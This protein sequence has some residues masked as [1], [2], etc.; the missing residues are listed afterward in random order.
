MKAIAVCL[1]LF[2][3][4]VVSVFVAHDASALIGSLWTDGAPTMNKNM[5]IV[6]GVYA[7]CP[8][9]RRD[10]FVAELGSNRNIC[11]YG[12]ERLKIGTFNDGSRDKAVVVFPYSNAAH[13]LEGICDLHCYYA[14]DTDQLVTLQPIGQFGT[15]LV[16]YRRASHRI[17]VDTSSGEGVNYVFDTAHPDYEMK[18]DVGKYILT[19][20]F[21]VSRNGNWVVAELRSQGIATINTQSLATKQVTTT[22]IAYGYGLDPSEQLAISNDG[23]SVALAGQN[24]G[25]QVFDVTPDCGQQLIDTLSVLVTTRQCPSTDLGIRQLF[26]NFA[27][28]EYPRFFG[29][30]HQ[31]E[32]TVSSWVGVSRRVSFVTQGTVIAPQLKLLTLGDSFSS[33]EGEVSDDY[34][35]FGT[36][37]QFDRCHVSVRSYSAH[38]ATLLGIHDDEV[39]NV[40]CSGARIGDIV[41]SSG[42]YWGQG[43]RLGSSG[44]GVSATEKDRL[45][46]LAVATYQPGR[47]LQSAFIE[48]YDPEIIT[49]GVGGNDA[50]LMGKLRT[51]AMPGTC[52]WVKSPGLE[53]T[54]GEIK[55]LYDTLSS[56][57]TEVSSIAPHSK[58]FVLGYPDIIDP[59]GVCDPLLSFLLDKTE[60][61]FVQNSIHYMNTV[62]RAA[63]HKAN[64]HYVDLEHSFDGNNLCR[65]TPT[66]MNSVRI[67]DDVAIAGVLPMLKIIGTETFHPTPRG[68]KLIADTVLDQYP[69]LASTAAVS[70]DDMIEP[71]Y[72]WSEDGSPA[73]RATY[74]TDFAYE[75]GLDEQHISVKVPEMSLQPG[76]IATI[77]VHSDPKTLATFV[78]DNAGAVDGSIIIPNS[79]DEGFHTLHLL[80]INM[81]GEPVD[82]YQFISIGESGNIVQ[83]DTAN[84]LTID[85]G[86]VGER[87]DRTK[88]P[89]DVKSVG[90]KSV[91]SD[92]LGVSDTHTVK[93]LVAATLKN[94][95]PVL[96]SIRLATVELQWWMIAIAACCITLVSTLC[97]IFIQRRWGKRGS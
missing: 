68:H 77:E 8:T 46:Q 66:A 57:F 14:A 53:Q 27:L 81:L 24:S 3:V 19:P 35:Q 4:S 87:E 59:D 88:L 50:G 11:V 54:A 69:G 13:I 94:S 40:A 62:I 34:Y 51:C 22:G 7:G 71:S 31:L 83:V 43:N 48:R 80:A 92:V 25:F 58:V 61:I 37:Q 91:L 33:G 6:P 85:G 72:Y 2:F 20:S 18:N 12:D 1:V 28:A 56:F 67:G 97:A 15:G 32:V 41:G 9:F 23:K 65:P 30:G 63:A 47:A 10:V 64:F 39:K 82:M 78:V 55:R 60:R 79:L 26:P 17:Q 75:D 73:A 49:I 45:Q 44:L 96:S 36:N 84:G 21:G 90:I 16:I 70:D 38:V 89:A 29:D 76:S 5:P 42:T 74:L 52:E 93:D 86:G 95:G